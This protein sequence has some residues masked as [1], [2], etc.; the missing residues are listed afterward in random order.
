MSDTVSSSGG[1]TGTGVTLGL[2]ATCLW[3]RRADDPV[4]ARTEA[5]ALG[6]VL[7]D[8]DRRGALPGPRSS[9]GT[10]PA[11]TI[12]K[13]SRTRFRRTSRRCTP[14]PGE[15]TRP[16]I[17][18]GERPRLRARWPP[19]SDGRG[20]PLSRP[21]PTLDSPQ[22]MARRRSPRRARTRLA[23]AVVA[24]F[25][26]DPRAH[27]PSDVELVTFR[28]GTTTGAR[29]LPDGRI[30]FSAAFEEPP[31]ELFVRP[32]GSPSAQALGVQDARLLAASR[33]GQLAIKHHP[34]AMKGDWSSPGTLEEVPSTGGP[35]RELEELSGRRLVA[36]GPAGD[37]PQERRELG[38]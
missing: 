23:L 7:P 21:F 27:I 33:T 38:A 8:V 15:G 18:V 30:V 1:Q 12:R 6:A 29:F 26:R 16:T 32:S 37:D 2:P 28:W 3:S 20:R 31:E 35:P 34:G 14:V 10:T 22:P 13:R 9:R 5:F 17:P 25:H 24:R 11:H 4:D 19:D 36:S